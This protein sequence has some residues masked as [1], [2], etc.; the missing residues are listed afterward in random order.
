MADAVF[1]LYTLAMRVTLELAL[2]VLGAIALTG[3]VISLV[4][5]AFGIQDQ[6]VAFTPKIVVIAVMMAWLGAPAFAALL[7]LLVTTCR[8][9]PRLIG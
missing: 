9:L 1:E 4:Q 8:G 3:V 7:H 6:N 2:P 5:T